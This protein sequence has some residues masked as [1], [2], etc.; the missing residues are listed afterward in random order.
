MSRK[1]SVHSELG[2]PSN[3]YNSLPSPVRLDKQKGSP[4]VGSCHKFSDG[5]GYGQRY[6]TA[7]NHCTVPSSVPE[8][9]HPPPTERF[10]RVT[11]STVKV[12][13]DDRSMRRNVD[14]IQRQTSGEVGR[15]LLDPAHEGERLALRMRQPHANLG[16]KYV[17]S[18]QRSRAGTISPL[19]SPPRTE[20]MDTGRSTG[21]AREDPRAGM[22]TVRSP[23]GP[24]TFRSTF[25]ALDKSFS[26]VNRRDIFA[27]GNA[28]ARPPQELVWCAANN[29]RGAETSKAWAAQLRKEAN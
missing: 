15:Y 10:L 19:A 26:N 27:A 4:L 1:S 18:P 20:R 12:G 25:K 6:L 22:P 8:Y 7:R 2:S 9:R 23:E 13:L 28:P 16:K 29:N 3:N 21:S 24:L 17:D 11:S 14:A 5:Y